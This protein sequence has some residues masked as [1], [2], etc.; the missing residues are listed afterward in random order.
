MSA[1]NLS[2]SRCRQLMVNRAHKGPRQA[3]QRYEDREENDK[4]AA[5]GIRLEVNDGCDD[6]KPSIICGDDAVKSIQVQQEGCWCRDAEQDAVGL[7]SRAARA[8]YGRR[9]QDHHDAVAKELVV[10]LAFRPHRQPNQGNWQG[11]EMRPVRDRQPE[12]R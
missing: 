10:K 3:Q 5:E 9:N 4:D 1:S 8:R 12:L 2:T 7:T 6:L 11:R